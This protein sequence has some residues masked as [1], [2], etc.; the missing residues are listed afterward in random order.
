MRILIAYLAFASVA[1]A[2]HPADTNF[3]NS[4]NA[5]EVA[6]YVDAQ[7]TIDEAYLQAVNIWKY[8]ERY[9][10]ITADAASFFVP[11][12]LSGPGFVALETL[13][14]APATSV[15]IY[16][17]AP[18]PG[19][20]TAYYQIPGIDEVVMPASVI[21]TGTGYALAIAPHPIKPTEGGPVNYTIYPAGSTPTPANIA[22]TG[23]VIVQGLSSGSFG[24]TAL[25]S[26]AS[27]L[28]TRLETR[29]DIDYSEYF[30]GGPK[31]FGPFS[32]EAEKVQIAAMRY[33][34]DP[35]FPGGLAELD[36]E[37]L[38][39]DDP[40]IVSL[41]AQ[42]DA[43]IAQSGVEA[44][45]DDFLA[46]L[47][48]DGGAAAARSNKTAK[49][50]NARE[51][52]P[53]PNSDAELSKL[54]REQYVAEQMLNEEIFS[55]ETGAKL[56][57]VGLAG[58]PGKV[59]AAPVSV[60]ITGLRVEYEKIAN[61]YPAN[62]KIEA[63][64]PYKEF[65]QDECAKQG[66]WTAYA[67]VSSKG[68]SIDGVATD[69]V[70]T[71]I[72][73]GGAAADGI[74]AFKSADVVKKT[75]DTG[76]RTAM[77]NKSVETY[78][79]GRDFVRDEAIKNYQNKEASKEIPS[80][81]WNVPIAYS[82]AEMV[83]VGQ[84]VLTITNN[85]Y[86]PKDVGAVNVYIQAQASGSEAFPPGRLA[87]SD[88]EQVVVRPAYVTMAGCPP[89]NYTPGEAYTITATAHDLAELGDVSY[90][91]EATEG[92]L[93]NITRVADGVSQAVWTAPD[94]AP[95][96]LVTITAT[97][98]APICAPV[99]GADPEGFCVTS[100]TAFELQV[101]PEK[102][103]Y[104]VGEDVTLT[105]VDVNNPGTPPNVEFTQESGFHI[106]SVQKTGAN[107]A[108]VSAFDIGEIGFT[109]TPNG[110]SAQ[111]QFGAFAFGACDEPMQMLFGQVGENVWSV[112]F[113]PDGVNQYNLLGS[114]SVSGGR[115]V[116]SF[117]ATQSRN[118]IIALGDPE[119]EPP[120]VGFVG[121]NTAG[122]MPTPI[123]NGALS[124][125]ISFDYQ[126]GTCA[127]PASIPGVTCLE[128]L[129]PENTVVSIVGL[130]DSYALDPYLAGTNTFAS[131]AVNV[132]PQN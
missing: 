23:Q 9:R 39:G 129:N 89:N 4:I 36:A 119:D 101:T 120:P 54:M 114:F 55:P 42:V 65:F 67:V 53:S 70:L 102:G 88:V 45:I 17:L 26:K 21:T 1:L 95:H 84:P 123:I 25:R 127:G 77:I 22:L 51:Y 92:T 82:Y 49:M 130:S 14:P 35:N 96:G 91:W 68:W 59:A 97:A 78:Q 11:D 61:T 115:L 79:T 132:V 112:G 116:A 93:S 76:V 117:N 81:T 62:G 52:D 40:A 94:P 86:Q 110:E 106:G 47:D 10:E 6:A 8:G 122:S 98:R 107:T 71:A 20:Y 66:N 32:S 87:S 58:A 13:R 126:E 103:C 18:E 73:A 31:E 100:G 44:H 19:G 80:E 105:L 60:T 16:G 131:Y 33:L 85:Y 124:I 46:Q 43:L 90:V 111:L 5:G 2:A 128:E 27:T 41:R 28:A 108:V 64:F 63:T 118:L 69:V 15:E 83:Q 113:S 75:Y 34:L 24:L 48:A 12:P 104:E 56:A 125:N 38:A 3:D 109:A 74:K 37:I 50:K 121:V 72:G 99:G 57:V 29:N 30:T 7:G